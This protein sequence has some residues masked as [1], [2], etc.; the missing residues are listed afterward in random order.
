MIENI[1][2]W[3]RFGN[4]LERERMTRRL[5]KT[6][7][8]KSSGLSPSSWYNLEH[9]GRLKD[10]KRI[11]HQPTTETLL[12]I[13]SALDMDPSEVFKVAGVPAPPAFQLREPAP[14]P[15]DPA[16]APTAPANDPMLSLL[17]TLLAEQREL[18]ATLQALREE[19][20]ALRQR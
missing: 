10:G 4:W 13:A 16:P 1:D 15:V 8:T 7:A 12:A 3:V 6:E 11:A 20:S 2:R 5:S 17:A 9:G 14:L 19:V 18:R